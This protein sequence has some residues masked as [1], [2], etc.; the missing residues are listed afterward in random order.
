MYLSEQCTTLNKITHVSTSVR[1]LRRPQ[2]ARISNTA[3]QQLGKK[4]GSP[5]IG[6]G[7]LSASYLPGMFRDIVILFSTLKYIPVL[8]EKKEGPAWI[9][10]ERIYHFTIWIII[11]ET[12]E[13]PKWLSA[14][15]N[16]R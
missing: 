5:T 13:E 15:T 11:V 12:V 6:V 9:E 14:N 16:G 10:I 2:D 1:K 8:L 4:I 3:H 7:M